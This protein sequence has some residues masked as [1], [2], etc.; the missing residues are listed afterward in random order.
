MKA[1]IFVSAE[2]AIVLIAHL[3]KLRPSGRRRISS[4][5]TARWLNWEKSPKRMRQFIM[6]HII[7]AECDAVVGAAAAH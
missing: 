7:N 5:R 3:R 6:D 2:A 1:V 4:H